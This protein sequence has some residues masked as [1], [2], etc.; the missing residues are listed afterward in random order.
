MKD[1]HKGRRGGPKEGITIEQCIQKGK[2]FS[3]LWG[4]HREVSQV[5]RQRLAGQWVSGATS[6]TQIGS[7]G[8]PVTAWKPWALRIRN[9]LERPRLRI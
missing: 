2:D 8:K 3:V 1:L 7:E 4:D 6:S 9:R 5:E